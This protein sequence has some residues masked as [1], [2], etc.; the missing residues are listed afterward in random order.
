MGSKL[1]IGNT[2]IIVHMNKGRVGEDMGSKEMDGCPLT[3]TQFL[4]TKNQISEAEQSRAFIRVFQPDLW[5][6]ISYRL[7]IKLPNHDP[8]DFYPLFEINEAAKHVLHGTSQNSFLQPSVTSTT[9][10]TQ[11]AS[12][13]IKVEDLSTL[14]EQMAQSFLKVL[15][16]PKLRT[17]H[18]SSSTN[19]Q[20]TTTLDWL[21]CA[22]CGQ[23]S[24]FIAQCLVCADYITNKKCKRNPEGKIVLPNGQFTPCS[25]PGWFI[26]NRIDEWHK[27]NPVKSTSSSLMY[28]IN[29]AAMSSQT[30]V[31]TNMVSTSSTNAF[32]A[33]QHIAALEQEIFNLRNAKRTFDGVEILKPACAN[34][35]ISTEQ[36]KAP[37]STTKS[38]PPPSQPALAEK[39]TTT[40][41]LPAHPFANVK[42][43]SYQPPHE[44]NFAA[45]PTKPAKDKE[46]AYHYVAPIQ[47]PCP[48]IDVYNKSMQA[49]LVTLSPE[50]LFAI[51]PEV[52][53]RLHEAIT[54]KRVLNK[55][56]STHALIEQVS[57][58]KET[59]IT[60]P[61]VYETYINSLAPKERPIPLNVAQ[62]L[63]ALW[64]ITIVINNREEVEG[65]ID[66]GSQII[67]MSEVVCHDISLAY[68]PSIKLNM[69]SANGEIDQS[70]GLSRNVPCKINTITLY[71]QI[72]IIR[73][74]AY[75]ILLGRPFNILTESTVK[76]FPNEDQ[77][78]TIVDPN[79]KHSVTIPTLPRTPLHHRRNGG[80]GF[81]FLRD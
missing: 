59:S 7:E 18:A 54:P 67:A 65:I 37:E 63:H 36:P 57:D 73:S 9:P 72:H 40:T 41:Q 1:V 25:I 50:E 6:Q 75:D 19:A 47:N 3:I 10:P 81:H 55:T 74:P 68:D 69:Q 22:F 43:T 17:N 62:E 56:V 38:A 58:D 79:T 35:P 28:E 44:C 34:K 26:K 51:S 13:Y 64:S 21:S 30:S 48:V 20:V 8:D 4:L 32:T 11:L 31:A 29:P 60:V 16:P 2:K 52:R 24:H 77:T 46:P 5:H 70:L 14:F 23:S 45:A 61:D 78:I 15:A 76:N 42:E 12:S 80:Q 27:H 49:P 53:N 39:P 33:D 66:P 71:L